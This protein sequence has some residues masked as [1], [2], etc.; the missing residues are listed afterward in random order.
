MALFKI[1][2]YQFYETQKGLL[3]CNIIFLMGPY[4][5]LISFNIYAL[6]EYFEQRL[7]ANSACAESSSIF[8]FRPSSLVTIVTSTG[9]DS[10]RAEFAHFTAVLF[11]LNFL[12]QGVITIRHINSHMILLFLFTVNVFGFVT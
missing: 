9:L 11:S 5:T 1:D 10:A 3:I 6:S 7:I 2:L 4:F 12:F 8:T